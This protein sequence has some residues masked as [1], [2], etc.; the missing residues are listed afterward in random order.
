MFFFILQ[1]ICNKRRSASFKEAL[2]IETDV[3]EEVVVEVVVETEE[4][5]VEVVVGREDLV[6]L[7]KV[8]P[9]FN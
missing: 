4:E 8:I 7:V 2:V 5:E 6:I 1:R 3:E 9:V